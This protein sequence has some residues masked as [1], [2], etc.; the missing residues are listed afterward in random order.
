M[1]PGATC[2]RWHRESTE[3]MARSPFVQVRVLSL[4]ES[5]ADKGERS[6]DFGIPFWRDR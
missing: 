5:G 1:L 4:V 6:G 2:V 3:S